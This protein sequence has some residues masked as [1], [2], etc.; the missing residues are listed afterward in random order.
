MKLDFL[1]QLYNEDD[2]EDIFKEFDFDL[3]DDSEFKEDAVREE[4]IFPLLKALGYSASGENKIIRSRI[5]KHPFYYFGTKK[6][7]VNIIPDYTFEVEN[8]PRW[9]LDAKR[10]TEKIQEGKNVYQAY[11][12]AMHPE[13]QSEIYGL[14]NGKEIVI[15]D[16]RKHTPILS[17]PIK[18]LKKN[19]TSLQDIL[20]PEAVIKPYIREFRPDFGIFILKIGDLQSVTESLNFPLD[21]L[22]DITKIEDDLYCINSLFGMD[23]MEGTEFMGTFDFSKSQFEELLK[24]I[25]HELRIRIESSLNSQ[26]FKYI[27]DEENHVN[28]VIEAKLG[29]TVHTNENESY[30]PF[31]VMKFKKRITDAKNP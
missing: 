12:Y 13:I 23:G 18:E 4:I 27:V 11:S 19:W 31:E 10:P 14:C 29:S 20:S 17:F 21:N 5:L 15:F 3:L 2:F 16:V 24:L 1:N 6:Y 8:K 9:I 26:P 28:L 30:L 7:D 22:N 25:P